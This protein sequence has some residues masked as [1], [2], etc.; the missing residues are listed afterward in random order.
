MLIHAGLD[1]S[2]RCSV[3]TPMLL[4]LNVHPSRQTDALNLIGDIDGLP[5]G[6]EA[7]QDLDEP[8]QKSVA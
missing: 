8:V 4:Q 7:R 6:G 5:L 1:V 2:F 3:Q